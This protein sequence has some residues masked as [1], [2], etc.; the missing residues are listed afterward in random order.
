MSLYHIYD[1]KGTPAIDG[2]PSCRR[3]FT[4]E[5]ENVAKFMCEI[6]NEAFPDSPF[7][8]HYQKESSDSEKVAPNKE[9]IIEWYKR[10]WKN[11]K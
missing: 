2:F 1:W 4:T 11:K 3:I 9:V 7:D 5:K 6:L 10:K 8:F